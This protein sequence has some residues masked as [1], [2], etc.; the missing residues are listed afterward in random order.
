MFAAIYEETKTWLVL[1]YNPNHSYKKQKNINVKLVYKAKTQPKTQ[2]NTL[3]C[4]FRCI[5]FY[6]EDKNGIMIDR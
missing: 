6:L 1:I 3:H 5:W 2:M 4:D